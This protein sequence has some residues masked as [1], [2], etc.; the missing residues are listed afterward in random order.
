MFFL[1]LLSR[2][3]QYGTRLRSVPKFALQVRIVKSL[4]FFTVNVINLLGRQ[5]AKADI[6]PPTG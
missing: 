2:T 1:P 3:Y 4:P 6:K 5:A